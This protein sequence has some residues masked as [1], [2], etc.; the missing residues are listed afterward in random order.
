MLLAGH[1]NQSNSQN[2]NN[3]FASQSNAHLLTSPSNDDLRYHGTELVMLYDYK[4]SVT[5]CSYLQ[6]KVRYKPETLQDKTIENKDWKQDLS[7]NTA[8]FV[9]FRGEVSALPL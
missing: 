9:N 5:P 4:V 3:N 2:V 7:I 1:L 8:T 6:I